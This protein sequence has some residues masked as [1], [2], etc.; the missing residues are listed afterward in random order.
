MSGLKL[1]PKLIKIGGRPIPDVRLE[2]AFWLIWL[3]SPQYQARIVGAATR[4]PRILSTFRRFLDLVI[5]SGQTVP[6]PT[7][8]NIVRR[9]SGGWQYRRSRVSESDAGPKQEA[10]CSSYSLASKARGGPSLFSAS[11]GRLIQDRMPWL[12]SVFVS[13]H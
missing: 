9:W 1:E 2:I 7:A 10:S 4:R 6:Y 3:C 13:Y 5:C 11:P 12:V 8:C